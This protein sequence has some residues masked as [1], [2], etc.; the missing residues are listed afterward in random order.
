MSNLTIKQL[1]EAGVPLRCI[2]RRVEPEDEAVYLRGTERY[3][4]HRPARKPSNVQ[5]GLN[6][7]EIGGCNGM[8]T[9]SLWYEKQA[10]ETNRREKASGA[11][12]ITVNVRWLGGTLTNYQTIEKSIDRLRKLRG[13]EGKRHLQ[14]LPK[15]RPS[16]S[17][18][19]SRSW[20]RTLAA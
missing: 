15:K 16:A 17:T 9:S 8:S 18:G 19:R 5:G 20:R 3:L 6:C 12:P 4:H 10:H 13:A 2:R 1:L 11:E 14:I 7:C